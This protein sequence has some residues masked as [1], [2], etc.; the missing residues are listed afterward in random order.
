MHGLNMQRLNEAL[1]AFMDAIPDA[2]MIYY[3]SV[4]II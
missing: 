4:L 1:K 3:D 2:I